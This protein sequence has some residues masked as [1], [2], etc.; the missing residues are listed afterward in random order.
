MAN[1]FQPGDIAFCIDSTFCVSLTREKAY[2][3][4]YS[5][6]ANITIL[7]DKGRW[8]DYSY[9]RFMKGIEAKPV[10]PTP[11]ELADKFR[12]LMKEAQDLKIKLLELGYKHRLS[13]YD[14]SDI[15]EKTSITYDRV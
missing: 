2:Y 15:F 3:V 13:N 7:N 14:G 1:P 5:D 9:T 10:E 12:E 4:M 8:T 11:K 6:K